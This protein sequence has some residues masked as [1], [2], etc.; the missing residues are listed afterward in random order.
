MGTAC[1]G[2]R[3]WGCAPAA[4]L[5]AAPRGGVGPSAE[6]ERTRT[7]GIQSCVALARLF[8]HA[9]RCILSDDFTWA[10]PGWCWIFLPRQLSAFSPGASVSPQASLGPGTAQHPLASPELFQF[11]VH[12]PNPGGSRRSPRTL[13]SHAGLGEPRGEP[14]HCI[15]H[16]WDAPHPSSS[17]EEHHQPF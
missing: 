3:F 4:V 15:T 6:L 13:R 17:Q 8:A 14:Q 1:I 2:A 10:L 12:S 11:H 16:G 5:P 9:M 7:Q